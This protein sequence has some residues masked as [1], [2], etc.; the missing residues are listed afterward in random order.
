LP[1]QREFLHSGRKQLNPLL[2]K[3][4]INRHKSRKI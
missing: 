4:Y 3:I 1:K 2:G